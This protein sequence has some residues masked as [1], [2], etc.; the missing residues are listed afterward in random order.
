MAIQTEHSL[1]LGV[2][3]KKKL[4]EFDLDISFRRRKRVSGYFRSFRLWKEYDS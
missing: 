3:I 4:K 2:E 1:Q